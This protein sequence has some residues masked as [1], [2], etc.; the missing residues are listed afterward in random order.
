MRDHGISYLGI[1]AGAWAGGVVARYS[2]GKAAISQAYSGKG[3]VVL[4]GPHPEAP[5]GWRN[6]A[7]NEPDLQNRVFCL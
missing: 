2:D 4:S 1:C 3:F 6:T 7:G 5:Q